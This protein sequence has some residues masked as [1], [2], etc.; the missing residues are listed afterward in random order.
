[1]KLNY[2]PL[3]YQWFKE[4]IAIE[5]S[6]YFKMNENKTKQKNIQNLWNEVEAVLRGKSIALNI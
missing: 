4:G 3:S 5:M 1:L 6:K 2:M